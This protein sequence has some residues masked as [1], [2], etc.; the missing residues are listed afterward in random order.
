MAGFP[1]DQPVKPSLAQPI[2]SVVEGP[3]AKGKREVSKAERKSRIIAAAREMIRESGDV[4][5]AMKGLAERAGLSVMTLYNLV[6]SQQD[7]VLQICIDDMIRTTVD[8]ESAQAGDALDEIFGMI[9]FIRSAFSGE[10]EYRRIILLSV[11][12][13]GAESTRRLT[14]NIYMTR[15]AQILE[16]ARQQKLL[17]ADVDVPMLLLALDNAYVANIISFSAGDISDEMFE[18]RAQFAFAL[19]ISTAVSRGQAQRV[20]VIMDDCQARCLELEPAGPFN[21]AIARQG[22]QSLLDSLTPAG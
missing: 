13:K 1:G 8:R 6:G 4:A 16:R 20:K 22:V 7:I 12:Q 2:D 21:L 19:A 15:W 5:F 17:R 10:F 3:R 18:A 14:R 11:F 9:P